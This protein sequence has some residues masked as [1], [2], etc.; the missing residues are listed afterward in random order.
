LLSRGLIT[1]TT[2]AS[3]APARF[4]PA[5]ARAGSWK[6]AYADILTGRCRLF[7]SVFSGSPAAPAG[8]QPR[9]S[10]YF[11]RFRGATSRSWGRTPP[12]PTRA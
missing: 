4:Y 11:S 7:H 10:G 6:V 5:A 1:G 9:I 3:G 8:A 12:I 2:P